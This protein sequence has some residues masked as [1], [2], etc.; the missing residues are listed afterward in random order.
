M[1][2]VGTTGPAASSARTVLKRLVLDDFEAPPGVRSYGI[3]DETLPKK[4]R[5]QIEWRYQDCRRSGVTGHCMHLRYA[6]ESTTPAQVSLRIDLGDLDASGYDHVELWIKGDAGGFSPALKI[7]FR[8][9]KPDL[10]RLMN[11]S[12]LR[13]WQRRGL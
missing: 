1:G 10:P 11:L 6:F 5:G 12:R 3:L 9:P 2:S 8:R 13:T 7:G 4:A